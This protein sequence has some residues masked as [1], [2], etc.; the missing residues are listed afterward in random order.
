[1]KSDSYAFYS[2]ESREDAR[3]EKRTHKASLAQREKRVKT[4]LR[5]T[6]RG[7]QGLINE[8][9]VDALADTGADKNFMN[10]NFAKEHELRPRYFPPDQRP[11]F[12]MGHGRTIQAVGEVEVSWE[13][14][15]EPEKPYTLHFFV[16]PDAIFDVMIGGPFLYET[17]TLAVNKHRLCVM[18]KPRRA[19][20]IRIVNFCGSPTRTLNGMIRCGIQE[21]QRCVALPDSGAEPNLLNYEYVKK[22]GWLHQIIPGPESC[23]LLMFADGSTA[24]TEGQIALQWTFEKRWRPVHP[25][26]EHAITFDVL[27]G[28]PVDIILG[29][30][31]LDESDCFTTQSDAFADLFPTEVSGLNLVIRAMEGFSLKSVMTKL[32]RK[33]SETDLRRSSVEEGI[34]AD[35]DAKLVDEELQRRAE[36]DQK[37]F[38]AKKGSAHTIADQRRESARRSEWDKHYDSEIRSEAD[39]NNTWRLGTQHVVSK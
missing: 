24:S 32:R 36:F 8:I 37:L 12:L 27:D 18:P 6:F 11:S 17:E 28:C 7:V 21:F 19:L 30:D 38:G 14:W 31:F 25:Q 29:Q 15:K 22:N 39:F 13:F 10:D 23:R 34:H 26:T 16:L 35:S 5:D 1:M 2:P 4:S 20:H 33:K 9:D 3:E